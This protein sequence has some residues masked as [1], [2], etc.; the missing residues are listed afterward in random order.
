MEKRIFFKLIW[1]M[2]YLHVVVKPCKI[3]NPGKFQW[4][5]VNNKL[6]KNCFLTSVKTFSGDS[7][8]SLCENFLKPSDDQ[9]CN[10]FDIS[11][12][13]I[14]EI[15]K[16]SKGIL[17][18]NFVSENRYFVWEKEDIV[19]FKIENADKVK[20]DIKKTSISGLSKSVRCRHIVEITTT[21]DT[22]LVDDDSGYKFKS[23]LGKSEKEDCVYTHDITVLY[24]GNVESISTVDGISIKSHEYFFIVIFWNCA[25]LLYFFPKKH[26]FDI[27]YFE[28][29]NVF[30]G[31]FVSGFLI[32]NILS[33]LWVSTPRVN[34]ILFLYGPPLVGIITGFSVRKKITSNALFGK[35]FLKFPLKKIKRV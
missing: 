28:P 31:A 5:K 12:L 10:K 25:F 16:I 3:Q 18:R 15:E 7:Y 21:R 6:L 22:E 11:K 2:T 35:I 8:L 34:G 19:N 27:F 32:D 14:D 30:F 13:S 9:K 4:I 1:I 33:F 17:T 24:D 23:K 20:F 26:D 29:R